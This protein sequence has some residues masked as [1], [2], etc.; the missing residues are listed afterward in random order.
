MLADAAPH[1]RATR[2][3]FCATK[4]WVDFT[5]RQA[6]VIAFNQPPP[7]LAS[8]PDSNHQR[9]RPAVTRIFRHVHVPFT[10]SNG[11]PENSSFFRAHPNDWSIHAYLNFRRPSPA[12]HRRV[13]EGWKKSLQT[14]ANCSAKHCCTREQRD[15]A[16]ELV[17][18]Y[19]EKVSVVP[20]QF[21]D[22]SK[23]AATG[24]VGT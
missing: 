5:R 15:R 6:S 1:T 18:R 16:R 20:N 21:F 19:D 11:H 3:I 23:A 17:A 24:I 10:M 14:I 4:L 2:S 7:L 12:Q 8:S 9:Y 13:L 22:F